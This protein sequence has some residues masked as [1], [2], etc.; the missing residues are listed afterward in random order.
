METEIIKIQGGIH[1]DQRG[2]LKYFNNFDL[3]P[4]KRF[5]ISEQP[6]IQIIKAWQAHQKERKWFYAIDGSFKIVLVK[7][8]NWEN[9]AKDLAYQEFI[10][11]ASE[12]E[13]L[14]IPAGFASGFQALVPHSRLMIFS[15]FTLEQSLADDF[16]FEKDMWYNW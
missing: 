4:I 10:L 1:S 13:V 3:Q 16:R 2:T 7:P 9:P 12:N 11:A 15:D 6:D 5:Y 8:D 14:S